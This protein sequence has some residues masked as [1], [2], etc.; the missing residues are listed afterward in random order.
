MILYCLVWLNLTFLS[1]DYWE[2]SRYNSDRNINEIVK[3]IARIG[4]IP[5]RD[6][7]ESVQHPQIEI[8]VP[9]G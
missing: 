9:L 2:N 4:I 1:L 7:C 3:L 6:E 8:L 5:L